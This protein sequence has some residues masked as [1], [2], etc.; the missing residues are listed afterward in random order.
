MIALDAG[1]LSEV[2]VLGAHCDDIAIGMGGTL[3]QLCEANPGLRVHAWVGSGAGTPREAEELGA[4]AAF[5]PGADLRVTVADLPDGRAPAH[6]ARA[7]AALGEFRRSAD[8]EVVFAPHRH[9][10]H[11]D[12]RQ[13]AELAPTEFRD[14]LI[15][16][17]EILKWETDTPRPT[18][19]V[20]L[21]ADTA[22]AKTR[23]LHE[24]YPSQTA[25]DWFDDE[26]FLGLARLRGVQCRAPY[27]EGFMVDKA[28]VRF[29]GRR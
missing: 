1:P 15:L 29:G 11:Q 7:K 9:D 8:P 10:A 3:L 4:L 21:T 25:H 14:Q 22:R 17:Y 26:A 12:H 23:L 13:L 20:P 2:A 16:G 19:L 28:I 24:H 5:A 18:V 27:A 6:W